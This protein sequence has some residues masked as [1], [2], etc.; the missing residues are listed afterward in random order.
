MKS[1]LYFIDLNFSW[2]TL[3]IGNLMSSHSLSAGHVPLGTGRD[4]SYVEDGDEALKDC[5]LVCFFIYTNLV[6]V[7]FYFGF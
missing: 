3:G 7:W 2:L 6:S 5:N 1:S 4:N